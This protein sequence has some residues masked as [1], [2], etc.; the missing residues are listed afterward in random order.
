MLENLKKAAWAGTAWAVFASG[1]LALAAPEAGEGAERALPQISEEA[2]S[3]PALPDVAAGEDEARAESA[4]PGDAQEGCLPQFV[5]LKQ[6]LGSANLAM[7]AVAGDAR[8]MYPFSY[9]RSVQDGHVYTLWKALNGEVAGY[10]LRDE[11]GYDFNRDQSYS[12]PLSWHPTMIFDRLFDPG[13]QLKGYS[14]V[15][16][17]RT[18]LSGHKVTMLKLVP[19]DGLR[20]TFLVASD[21]DS[22]LPVELSVVSPQGQL[23]YKI[24]ATDLQ[25]GQAQE[26][27]ADSVFDRFLPGRSASHGKL[28]P[29]SFLQV[30]RYFSLVAEGISPDVDGESCPYQ[31]Y[32][33]GLV[34]YRVYINNRSSLYLPA[35]VS[36]ALSVFRV[37]ATRREYAVV[38]E[39]PLEVAGEVFSK[40][41]T[42]KEP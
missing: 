13:R 17:G 6:R 26:R 28:E 2:E 5:Q 14:C 1:S 3:A 23:V 21:D 35:V 10:A 32:S 37:A 25:L 4:L 36:G 39:V 16:T 42:K 27:G 15:L 38:G 30:P 20:Y 8:G 34:D 18:R 19:Q 40:L 9:E 33:D 7:T 22:Q 11:Q 12:G 31:V 41:V 29:W 24:T